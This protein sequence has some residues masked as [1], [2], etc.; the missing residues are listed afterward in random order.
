G[1]GA[2]GVFACLRKK[3][4]AGFET[5]RLAATLCMLNALATPVVLGV[6][7]QI[8]VSL[9]LSRTN[10][11]RL[12]LIYLTAAIPFFLSG[13]QF[14]VVFARESGHIARLYAADL[15]GGALACLGVVPLLNWLGGPNAILFSAMVAGFASLIWTTSRLQR[16]IAVAIIIAFLVV[17]GLN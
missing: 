1:L 6:V 17:I 8:P 5:R 13:V 11:L 12:T 9:A 14:S 7:L 3:W 15:A 4:L 10:L 2:G 16:R